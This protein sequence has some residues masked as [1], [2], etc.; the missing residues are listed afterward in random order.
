VFDN[1]CLDQTLQKRSSPRFRA[2]Q[3]VCKDLH[4]D[5]HAIRRKHGTAF[6]LRRFSLPNQRLP[7]LVVATLTAI[8]VFL[9]TPFTFAVSEEVLYSFG[10]STTDGYYPYAGLALGSNGDPDGQIFG[11][12]FD[13]GTGNLGTVFELLRG[14]HGELM[15]KILYNFCSAQ[16]CEDGAN[17]QGSLLVDARGNLYGTTAMGGANGFGEVFKLSREYEGHWA[18]TVLHSF[19]FSN[20]GTDG[21]YPLSGVI[22][23]ASGTLYGTTQWGGTYNSGT[24]YRLKPVG[25]TWIETLLYSFNDNG[26]D[27]YEPYAPLISDNAGNL[28]GTTYSGGT[29]GKGCGGSG[30][31]TVFQLK[32]VG[33]GWNESVLFS[34]KDNL[35]DGF[36]PW[37]GVVFDEAGNLYGTTSGGGPMFG[38]CSGGCGT[39][40]QLS[41]NGNHWTE[42]VIHYFRENNIDGY[43]SLAGL[44]IDVQGALYG[45]TF[46]GGKYNDGIV[47]RVRQVNNK[48]VETVLHTFDWSLTV[49]DGTL[50]SS[51]L[52]LDKS[53]NL[54]G[55][56]QDGGNYNQGA[57]IEVTP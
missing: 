18:I 11:T 15:E 56:T 12:T 43:S 31:G 51:P 8:F 29:S 37:G 21:Y 47:F 23:D 49:K 16:N 57:V 38:G 45:T 33:K 1:E 44:A 55:T 5:S 9:A 53:G 42:N 3:P 52:V 36:K 26:Q 2:L 25:E 7:F 40:F 35:K 32:P 30:C 50:P 34:F 6:S 28:Y 41:P 10:S 24:V 39:V 22:M 27:G 4:L 48:W 54:Y 17:P 46:Y 14:A 19:N 20:Y 13:G